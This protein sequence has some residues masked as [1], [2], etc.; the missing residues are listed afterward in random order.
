MLFNSLHFV[1]FFPIVVFTYFLL[2]HKYR[3]ALLLLASYY[4]Y[5]CW[6]AEY[7]VLILVSTMVDF[8]I[9][10]KIH[11][12]ENARKRKYL[13]Y[14]SLALNLGVLFGFKYFNFVSDSLQTVLNSFNI[15]YNNQQF[16]VL[17]PVGISFYTFQTLSYTIDVYRRKTV[18]ENH[19]GKF[20]LYVSFFPQLVAGPIE[21]A[22]R[23]LPQFYKKYKFDYKRITSGLRLMFWGFFKK[24]VIADNL[25]EYVNMVYS[26]P[27]HFKGFVIIVATFFFAWQVYCDFS[28]YADIAVGSARILG[29]NLIDNFRRPYFS[30]SMS[31]FWRR[32]HISLMEWFKDYIYIPLGGNRVVKW[33]WYYNIIIVFFVSGLW[34]GAAWT[35]IIFG[36]LNGFYIVFALITQS[37]RQKIR[38]LLGLETYPVLL[39]IIQSTT[40]VALFC[41]AL[42]F[43]RSKNLDDAF[44]LISNLLHLDFAHPNIGFFGR[45]TVAINFTLIF[46]LIGIHLIERTKK[47][48]DYIGA[49]NKWL[50]W[51]VYYFM[52]LITL[53]LGNFGLKEFIYFQF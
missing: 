26:H 31:E 13:L 22:N 47:I 17:L 53:L 38:D 32:W 11:K 43:F 12:Q 28:G 19:F 2:S 29:F 50:R 8:I 14:V 36:I 18:P 9:A 33:Q 25:A 52:L 48:E 1:A 7:I 3:W 40:V 16:N 41:F 20:A 35:F 39:K 49:K 15:F 37:V 45:T 27:S 46:I 10:K 44:S 24:I 30:K 6:K 51:F 5:I 4:F 34:H 42:I 21:R 23:L